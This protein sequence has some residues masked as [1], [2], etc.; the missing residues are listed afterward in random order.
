MELALSPRRYHGVDTEDFDYIFNNQEGMLPHEAA[1]KLKG[2]RGNQG[3]EY[4]ASDFSL[5][6][7]LD[8]NESAEPI[9]HLI[10]TTKA[11]LTVTALLA[12]RHRLRPTSAVCLLQNGMGLI[13]QID[14]IVFPDPATRP[15]Y[16]Q[17]IVSHGAN[18]PPGASPFFTLHAGRGTIALTVLPRAEK[19]ET[20]LTSPIPHSP[21]ARHLMRSLT[22]SPVLAAISLPHPE[23][24]QQK[25]EKL[26]Q[27]AVINPLTVL[28][29]ARNGA[30]NY[31]FA[32]TK[33]VRL[34]LA[35]ISLV[36]RSLPEL[37]GLPSLATRFAPD[38]L[39]TLVVA[40]ATKT[41]NNVSSMLA[42][43]RNGRATEVKY[44]NGYI[45]KR[46]EE[47]GITCLC[48]YMVMQTVLGK[49]K[50]VGDEM[51]DVLPSEAPGDQPGTG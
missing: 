33:V 13:D 20:A 48:N 15:I 2:D 42:D 51:R 12:V 46:G 31:N 23:F 43:V 28:L 32:I 30:L 34:L 41:A 19:P 38:R 10:V 47:L 9:D 21:A 37:K 8:P 39:E 16:I 14:S 22:R 44:I 26:A 4:D 5:G 17:G 45:V 11:H 35:E 27:N 36:L 40:I 1:A 18:T 49:S 6:R 25:L 7:E 29:D 24:L 3:P 50:M